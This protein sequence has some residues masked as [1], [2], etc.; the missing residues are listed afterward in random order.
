MASRSLNLVFLI[1]NLTRDPELRYTSSGTPIA[2]F[3]VATNRTYTDSSGKTV[4]TAEFHNV[5]AWA[6]LAEICAQLLKKGAKV[7]ITGRLQTS[8]WDDKETGKTM[9]KTEI[10]AN[11]MI[12]LSPKG[13]NAEGENHNATETS[14]NS[15]Q[16]E[17]VDLKDLDLGSEVSSDDSPSNTPF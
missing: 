17:D 3:G 7:H 15:S 14:S 4:E 1:G 13:S 8:S 9:R 5:V 16:S 11:E 6:K 2:T 10:V 12:I